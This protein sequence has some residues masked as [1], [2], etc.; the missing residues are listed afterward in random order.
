MVRW[1]VGNGRNKKGPSLLQSKAV[2]MPFDRVTADTD[3]KLMR[4]DS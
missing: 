4:A 3:A 2:H 1:C